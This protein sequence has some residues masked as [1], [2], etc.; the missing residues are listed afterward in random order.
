MDAGRMGVGAGA[1]VSLPASAWFDP[2]TGNIRGV[3]PP[4]EDSIDRRHALDFDRALDTPEGKIIEAHAGDLCSLLGV[5]GAGV[6]L[7]NRKNPA[8]EHL[9]ERIALGSMAAGGLDTAI[10]GYDLVRD[11]GKGAERRGNNRATLGTLAYAATG[12][13]PAVSLGAVRGLHLHPSAPEAAG[14]ALFALNSS[15]L[16]YELVHRVPRIAKGEE[17][18]S[19]YG[20]LLASMGGFVVAQHFV[21]R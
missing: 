21:R 1:P 4:H 20:S 5:V 8:V 18:I 13:I 12:L 2:Q 10:Q 16:G 9:G 11:G 15:V 3:H 6:L 14:L 7:L 17:D 19:G